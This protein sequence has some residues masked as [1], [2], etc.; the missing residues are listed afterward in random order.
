LSDQGWHPED[1]AVLELAGAGQQW[2]RAVLCTLARRGV[3]FRLAHAER[4]QML[5]DSLSTSPVYRSGQFLFDLLELED[6]MID[7]EPPPVVP[8]VL[9][10]RSL[11]QIAAMIR[12]LQRGLDGGL[13]PVVE[14]PP[15]A[16]PDEA[17][18]AS[19]PLPELEPGFHLYADVVLGAVRSAAP[20][21]T[22]R[23]RS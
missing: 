6:F 10:E 1:R 7:G 12:R 3:E 14:P 8:T 17:A 5:L 23:R 19:Q 20:V 15:A 2:L 11:H 13:P 16:A 9:D 22:E 4:S 18:D 21:V